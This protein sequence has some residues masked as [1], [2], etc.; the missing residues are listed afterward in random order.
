MFYVQRDA[1]GQLIRVE[2]APF[3]ESSEQ[4]EADD[5]EIQSWFS[6][7]SVESSLLQLRQTDPEMI[8]VLEDLIH[9]LT[10]KGVLRITDLPPAAQHK[11]IHR[12][13]AREGLGGLNR[14]IGDDDNSLI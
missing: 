1:D 14:L 13:Q 3:A 2:A 5:Q 12:S 4:L 9:I 6:S 11:L 7:Q 8:R 10:T